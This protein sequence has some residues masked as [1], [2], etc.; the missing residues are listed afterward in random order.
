[1]GT[2]AEISAAGKGDIFPHELRNHHLDALGT[3]SGVVLTSGSDG[4]V[5]LLMSFF[6]WTG[7]IS[8]KVCTWTAIGLMFIFRFHLLR[9]KLFPGSFMF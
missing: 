9:Q 1:M 7:A 3:D 2:R 4:R 8:G 6:C 5:G